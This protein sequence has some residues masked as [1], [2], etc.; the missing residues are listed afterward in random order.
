MKTKQKRQSYRKFRKPRYSIN[1]H[2]AA[3]MQL[4]HI[5]NTIRTMVCDLSRYYPVNSRVVKS[6]DM[7]LARVD[8]LLNELDNAVFAENPNVNVDELG[9][10][11]YGRIRGKNETC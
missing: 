3:G 9:E 8:N 6:A 11:Y 7:A 2:E 5:S 10:I 4:K 1:Q